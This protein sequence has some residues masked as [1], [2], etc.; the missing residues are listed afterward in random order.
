MEHAEQRG[1]GKNDFLV[2][3]QASVDSGGLTK[4]TYCV[5]PEVTRMMI[6]RILTCLKK[7]AS[8]R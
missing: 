6:D 1:T 7:Q 5:F 4:Y 8:R 2:Y 3:L